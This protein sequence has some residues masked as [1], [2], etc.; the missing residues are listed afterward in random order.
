MGGPVVRGIQSKGILSNAKHWVLNSQETDRQ[1]DDAIVDER[2]RF[3]MYYPPYEGAI[4]AGVASFMC[5]FNRVNGEWSCGN[6]QTL[7]VDL[8]QRLGFAGFVMSDWGATHSTAIGAGLDMEMPGGRGCPPQ[9][10]CPTGTPFMGPAEP[11]NSCPPHTSGCI[12]ASVSESTLDDSLFRILAPMYEFGLFKNAAQWS[13]LSK[14]SLTVTSAAHSRLAREIAAA[15][16]VLLRNER[17]AL[18]LAE[19]G[20]KIA[21]IGAQA[22]TPSVHGGGSGQVTPT[23]VISPLQGICNRTAASSDCVYDAGSDPEHAAAV[24]AAADVVIVVVGDSSS[25]GRDRPNLSFSGGQDALVT[26]VAAATKPSARSIVVGLNPG[27]VLLPWAEQVDAVLLMFSPG[28]ECGHAL[29]DILWGDVNPS[30]RLPVTIPTKE[31]EVG[32]T[33][34]QY[35][36]VETGDHLTSHY[37]E[38]LE[39][40]YRWY[41]ARGAEPHF[42]FVK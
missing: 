4:A 20:K 27:P 19:G 32:L 7:A 33:K 10:V 31:N 22:A 37:I 5:S 24:A 36:G 6:K 30:A 42:A 18:P 25:E 14:R 38:R 23:Y 12:N 17:Q 34:A 41:D 9:T 2:T 40:G 29:A 8:K 21:V 15:A 16:T 11:D 39:I 13:D 26:T 3:E 28:L 35:P 1:G